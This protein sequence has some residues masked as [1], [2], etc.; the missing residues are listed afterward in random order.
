MLD[1]WA[2]AFESGTWPEGRT[3]VLGRPR[4]ASEEVRPVTFKL[5]ISKI[6]ALDRLASN[7]GETRSEFL[8]NVIDRELTAAIR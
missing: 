4:M 3:V 7:Q 1:E 2:D 8:R 5:P 6:N